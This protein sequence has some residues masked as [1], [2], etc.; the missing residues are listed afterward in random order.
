[1]PWKDITI[2]MD[3]ELNTVPDNTA[4]NQRCH[5][6]IIINIIIIII[7]ISLQGQRFP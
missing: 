1:M 7:I 6:I 5:F 3:V 2:Y 4:R